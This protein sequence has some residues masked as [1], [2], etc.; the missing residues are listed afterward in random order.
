MTVSS[1]NISNIDAEAVTKALLADRQ[2]VAFCPSTVTVKFGIKVTDSTTQPLI[3]QVQEGELK[4]VHR[5]AS[6]GT[7]FVLAADAATWAKHFTEKQ[8]VGFQSFWCEYDQ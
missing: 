7:D 8:D 5:G 1:T 2:F 4:K 3:V 6:A